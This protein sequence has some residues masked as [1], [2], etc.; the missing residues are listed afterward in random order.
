MLTRTDFSVTYR[1][2]ER[3]LDIGAS[4]HPR[5]YLYHFYLILGEGPDEMPESDWNSVVETY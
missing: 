3:Y 1:N 4:L 5:D 2:G